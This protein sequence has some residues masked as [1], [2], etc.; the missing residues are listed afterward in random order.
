MAPSHS[1]YSRGAHA[2]YVAV[3]DLV[4]LVLALA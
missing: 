3:G 4:A 2:L 1:Y